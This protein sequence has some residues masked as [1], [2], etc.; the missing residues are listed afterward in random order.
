MGGSVGRQLGL[1]ADKERRGEGEKAN[2]RDGNGEIARPRDLVVKIAINKNASNQQQQK[3]VLS[4]ENKRGAQGWENPRGA[5][6]RGQCHSRFGHRIDGFVLALQLLLSSPSA[7]RTLARHDPRHTTLFVS[8][9]PI[10]EIAP[11]PV[12]VLASARSRQVDKHGP[13]PIQTGVVRRR[14]CL[15]G[16]TLLAHPPTC[17][18]STDM[19]DGEENPHR[20]SSCQMPSV[21]HGQAGTPIPCGLTTAAP[22]R[23]T[24]TRTRTHSWHGDVTARLHSGIFGTLP[25]LC[26]NNG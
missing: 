16:A 7:F 3:G 5:L 19:A 1:R 10:R 26:T 11:R 24:R 4:L 12:T 9:Q 2:G 22:T 21:A 20:A 23:Q 17:A 8:I 25:K 15:G 18:I 14:C 13:P 6:E